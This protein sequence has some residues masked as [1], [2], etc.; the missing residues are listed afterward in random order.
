M[1]TLCMCV[2]ESKNKFTFLDFIH[3]MRDIVLSDLSINT[4]LKFYNV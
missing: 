1:Y 2:Y 4:S 3:Q